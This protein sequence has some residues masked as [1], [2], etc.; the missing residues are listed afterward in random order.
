MLASAVEK[1]PSR[2]VDCDTIGGLAGEIDRPKVRREKRGSNNEGR[3]FWPYLSASCVYADRL[4]ILPFH[5]H[6][7][8]RR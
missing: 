4:V 1:D 8:S 3:L 7:K 6:Q 5:E 2:G